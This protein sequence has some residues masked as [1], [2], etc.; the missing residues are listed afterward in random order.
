M[1]LFDNDNA[2]A[3]VDKNELGYWKQGQPDTARLAALDN[4]VRSG[5]QRR[6]VLLALESAGEPGATDFEVF[7]LCNTG[8]GSC[9]RPHVAGTRRKELADRGL[10]EPTGD[11]RQTDTGSLA[12]VWRLTDL[13]RRVAGRVY[14]VSG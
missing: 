14:E 7:A 11:R 13:G 2:A 3:P 10:V 5:T 12:T 6:R 4:Y 9:S 1:T 8:E